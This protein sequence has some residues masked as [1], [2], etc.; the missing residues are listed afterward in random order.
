[1][2]PLSTDLSLPSMLSEEPEEGGEE[3]SGQ[4]CVAF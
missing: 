3:K 2:G 1:M 4:G